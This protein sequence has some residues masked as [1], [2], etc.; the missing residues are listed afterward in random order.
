VAIDRHTAI[1]VDN[2]SKLFRIPH[3]KH[4]TLKAAVL[5][6]F[7][8]KR[9]TEFQALN[10]ISF[11]VKKGEFFGII[12]RNGCGKST[13]LKIIAGIYLPTSG[14]VKNDGRIS[15]FL[16]LGVGFNPELTARENIYLNGAILGLTR[17]EINERFDEILDFAELEEFVDMKVK[18]FSSGMHV[19]LAFS[20]AI[21]AHAEILLIDEV[22]AVGDAN[23]QTKC[24]NEFAKFKREGRTIMFVT[25]DMGLVENFCDRALLI[26]RGKLSQLGKPRNIAYE[27]N[28]INE[29]EKEKE[30]AAENIGNEG[31]R[32]SN[33]W[34]DGFAKIEKM[35][36]E[37]EN[38]EQKHIFDQEQDKI[39]Y[40]KARI[41]FYRTAENPI[42][43]IIVR[44]PGNHDI[45]TTNT[46]WQEMETGNFSS[47][48]EIVV[49]FALKNHLTKG[50]YLISAAIAYSDAKRYYDWRDNWYRFSISSNK[51]SSGVVS[52]ESKISIL[53]S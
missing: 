29:L 1:K 15:P 32:D 20:V 25:H 48:Q 31:N 6:V 34:G 12:G 39:I 30:L 33:R 13:L 24:I 8:K 10:K 43:G 45:Y 42:F 23:F 7:S 14:K 17:K 51:I 49:E 22:L 28:L 18:N 53:E 4:T 27:Y 19:R 9:Y 26:N 36:M 52:L 41:K 16:E 44:T 37:D 50:D 35:W 47:G 21:R 3:E 40:I 5:N 2:V 11:E 46:L 38:H